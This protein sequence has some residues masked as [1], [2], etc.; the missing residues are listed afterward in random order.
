MRIQIN[1]IP[2][3]SP[4]PAT[5]MMITM[6]KFGTMSSHFLTIVAMIQATIHTLTYGGGGALI[7]RIGCV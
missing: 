1:A 7:A 6:F 3:M 5:I 4:T 2:L